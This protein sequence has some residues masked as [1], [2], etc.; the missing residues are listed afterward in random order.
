[1]IVPMETITI[2]DVL[3]SN[4]FAEVYE[5]GVRST[6]RL[7]A[8]KGAAFGE[9]EELAQE[10]WTRAWVARDQLRDLS[11][12]QAWVNMIAFNLFRSEWRRNQRSAELPELVDRAPRPSAACAKQDV[13]Q[14][15]DR[16]RPLDREL[17]VE[18]FVEEMDNNEIAKRHRMTSLAVRVRVHRARMALQQFLEPGRAKSHADKGKRI[19]EMPNRTERP[20][21]APHFRS[22]PAAS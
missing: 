22:L 1:M 17:L 18:R 16:C 7:L 19:L 2:S 20:N 14:A 4:V 5:K 11:R 13:S 3:N 6:S 10:A 8:S 21:R 9:A 15:L 12:V